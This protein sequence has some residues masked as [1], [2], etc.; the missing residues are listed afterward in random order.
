[1]LLTSTLCSLLSFSVP[2]IPRKLY[3]WLLAGILSVLQS[4]MVPLMLVRIGWCFVGKLDVCPISVVILYC[5]L[6]PVV[7]ELSI[8]GF[9]SV[10]F[11]VLLANIDNCVASWFCCL[12]VLW[13]K[14]IHCSFPHCAI[15]LHCCLPLWLTLNTIVVC[16]Q[17]QLCVWW[18]TICLVISWSV[19]RVCVPALGVFV[20]YR[21]WAVVVFHFGLH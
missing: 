11:D 16:L 19:C 2:P 7:W 9:R 4:W 12:P 20:L 21:C 13:C 14:T 17:C 18:R 1:M 10:A 5:W 6:V 3:G 8:R 15:A